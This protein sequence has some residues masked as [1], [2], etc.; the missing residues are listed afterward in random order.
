MRTTIAV[1]NKKNQ[2]ALPT[3]IDALK[4]NSVNQCLNFTIA[5]PEK[6]L[7]HENLDVL[8]KQDI[9]SSTVIGCSFTKEAK[10]AYNFL[11]LE[12]TVVVFEG[13]IHTAI[14]KNSASEI[15]KKFSQSE[16]QL[17]TL[18]KKVDGNYALFMLKEKKLATIRDSI[19]AQPLYYG[20][21]EEVV[22]FAS[23]RKALWQLDINETISFPPGNIGLLT[24]T[25]VDFKPIKTFTYTEPKHVSMDDATVELQKLF[26]YNVKTQVL[27]LKEVAVAFSG[28]LDSSLIAYMTN[29]CGVKVNL[30]HVSLENES[31]TE[32]AF[33]ASE[34]MNLPMQAYLFK[35]SDVENTLPQVVDIIEDANPVKVAIGV[36]LYWTGQ[37]AREADHTVLLAGQGADE[38]FGGYQRYVN[39]YCKYGN[40]KTRQT[41]FKDVISIHENNLERDKKI[42]INLDLE[43]LLPFT[44]FN[45]VKFALGLPVDLKMEQKQ[46]TLRKLV[47]RR[48]ALNLGLPTSIVYKPKKAVQYSTGINN[49]IKRIAQKRGQTVNEYISEF[50]K[51]NTKNYYNNSSKTL[52]IFFSV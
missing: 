30:I 45:M 13:I 34:K 39:E 14:T 25:G 16:A 1:F 6:T 29:K 12:N 52:D 20:E 44:S 9:N 21:N 49:A 2:P 51:E 8:S 18:I 7:S 37:K 33:E 41:M 24:K 46:D 50:F 28:G 15:I 40:E 32:A 38:L 35:D 48:A 43:L 17:Q 36:P 3:I 11:Q 26:E 10:K 22:A 23:N 47:L 5:S 19:G 31:E 4:I 27:G 42:C